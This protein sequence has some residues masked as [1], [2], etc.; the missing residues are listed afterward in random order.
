M[1]SLDKALQ[2]LGCF[3]SERVVIGV[4]PVAEELGMPKS[5]VSR[6]MKSMCEAGLLERPIGHRGYSPGVMAFRLGNLYQKQHRLPDLVERAVARLVE[7]F[8]LTGYTGVLD[9]TDIVLTGVRQGSYPVR[10]VL[11]K[12]M[13]IPGHVT[14][15]GLAILAHL[16][17]AKVRALYPAEIHYSE[18]GQTSSA[19]DIIRDVE[20][21]RA[22]GV[23]AVQGITYPGFNAVGTAVES[24]EEGQIIGFSLSYPQ[25]IQTPELIAD[26]SRRI[27]E[28]AREI[29]ASVG[30]PY[31]LARMHVPAAGRVGREPVPARGTVGVGA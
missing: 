15:I 25:E 26:I 9:G 16:P 23:A 27:A 22:A 17:D 5:S 13:R 2:I 30:D 18:T 28:A 19:A 1:S 4:S 29:G 3:S 31:W 8:G 20:R 11:P 14:A 7:E 10:L 12:G 6:L 21:V 24:A